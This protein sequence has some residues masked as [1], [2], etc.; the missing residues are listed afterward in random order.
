MAWLCKTVPVLGVQRGLNIYPRLFAWARSKIPLNAA[1]TA[2]LLKLID[3]TQVLSIRPFGDEEELLFSV[4][5]VLKQEEDRSELKR[6]EK[7]VMKQM[8]DIKILRKRCAELEG[9]KVRRRTKGKRFVVDE[10]GNKV[11][12]EKKVDK[13]KEKVN[14]EPAHNA[15]AHFADFVDVVVQ[16]VV[17]DLAKEKNELDGS[18]FENRSGNESSGRT[19]AGTSA[20]E[21]KTVFKSSILDNV[22]T[23]AD[24]VKKKKGSMFVTRP[25]STPR[26]R[27]KAKKQKFVDVEIR[28]YSWQGFNG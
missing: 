17:S 9:E 20:V 24:R 10:S 2:T 15:S 21:N 19:V 25:S 8:A 3:S 5:L 27:R 13:A 16:E 18:E 12:S 14:F 23:R 11:E 4:N 22:R 28:K 6:F 1:E 7:L 26:R